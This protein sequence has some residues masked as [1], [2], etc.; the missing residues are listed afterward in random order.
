MMGA[1]LARYRTTGELGSGGMGEVWRAR[2]EE[3]DRGVQVVGDWFTE[4]E[5]LAGEAP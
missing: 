1:T 5:S 4:L 2:E 3:L